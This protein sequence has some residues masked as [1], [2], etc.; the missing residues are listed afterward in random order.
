MDK[1]GAELSPESLLGSQHWYIWSDLW[2]WKDALLVPRL[3]SSPIAQAVQQT[4]IPQHESQFPKAEIRCTIYTFT[5]WMVLC[6]GMN[7]S[8][9]VLSY[10]SSSCRSGCGQL[11]W[12]SIQLKSPSSKSFTWA[13][14]SLGVLWDIR[15]R[16]WVGPCVPRDGCLSPCNALREGRCSPQL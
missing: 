6:H 2:L 14:I 7:L 11:V 4:A 16:C 10:R 1:P 3:P 8:W 12:V 5:V 13:L 15:H 9:E